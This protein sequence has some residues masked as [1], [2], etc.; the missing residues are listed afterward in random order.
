MSYY[1]LGLVTPAYPSPISEAVTLARNSAAD[2]RRVA[3]GRT[4]RDLWRAGGTWHVGGVKS[5]LV[6]FIMDTAH[7][8]LLLA[9]LY[10]MVTAIL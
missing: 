2:W 5:S 9:G 10:V 3:K 6:T 1:Q 4:S 7:I 8:I